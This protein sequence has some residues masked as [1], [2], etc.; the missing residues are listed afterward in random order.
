MV[1]YTGLPTRV[2][3]SEMLY[4][5]YIQGSCY[6]YSFMFP[7]EIILKNFRRFFSKP[8]FKM[9]GLRTFRSSLKSPLLWVTLYQGG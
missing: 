3:T 1:S 9:L 7:F 2:E 5:L 6:H 8:T 4:F